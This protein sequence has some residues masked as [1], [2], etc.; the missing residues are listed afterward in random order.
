M[1]WPESH[2]T[3]AKYYQQDIVMRI[4]KRR[5]ARACILQEQSRTEAQT[6]KR[7]NE[8]PITTKA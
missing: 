6:S 4:E 5:L 8:Q 1:H 2:I 3:A 7:A